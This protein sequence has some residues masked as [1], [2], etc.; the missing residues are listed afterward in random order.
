MSNKAQE[1]AAAVRD[2]LY[3]KY[4]ASEGWAIAVHQQGVIQVL[5]ASHEGRTT[6]FA[7]GVTRRNTSG[8][9]TIF[10]KAID[11]MESIA[12]PTEE[13]GPL[14]PRAS[15]LNFAPVD[16]N[17][18]ATIGTDDDLDFAA[19]WSPAEALDAAER[20]TRAARIA[21]KG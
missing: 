16:G 3:E 2:A 8:L 17:V 12:T 15:A 21:L 14:S 4:P 7:T 6:T 13:S 9:V 1:R 19:D 18:R 11:D 5:T 10:S 20:L